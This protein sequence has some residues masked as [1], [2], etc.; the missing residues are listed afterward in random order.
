MHGE[1]T[2]QQPNLSVLAI[3]PI[4][5]TI[6]ILFVTGRRLIQ[7]TAVLAF[8]LLLAATFDFLARLT[9]ILLIAS[10]VLA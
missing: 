10:A 9:R 8:A 5:R 7:R 3:V 6:A 4:H 1:I 2:T